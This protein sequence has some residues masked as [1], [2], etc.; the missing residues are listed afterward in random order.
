MGNSTVDA[1]A[2]LSAAIDAL[3]ALDLTDLPAEHAGEFAA[4]LVVQEQRVAATRARALAVFDGSGAAR[5]A[6]ATSTA[7]WLRGTANLSPGDAAAAV[8]AARTVRDLPQ[9]AE[10]FAAGEISWRHVDLLGKALRKHGVEHLR[11]AEPTLL[12]LAKAAPPAELA[13]ALRRLDEALDPDG[14]ARREVERWSKRRLSLVTGMDGL[15]FLDAVMADEDAELVRSVLLPL[16]KPTHLPDGTPDDRTGGQRMMDALLDA[17]KRVADSGTLPE[18][19]GQKPHVTLVVPLDTL[20]A[21]TRTQAGSALTALWGASFGSEELRQVCCDAAV[22]PVVVGPAMSAPVAGGDGAALDVA[23]LDSAALDPQE[24]RAHL[25]AQGRF[26]GLGQP[27]ALGESART[28]S[29]AQRRA[30]TVRDG[31]C[32]FPGCDRPP[33]FT[34][35]HHVVFWSH[36]GPTDLDNLILLC[37]RH[38]RIVHHDHWR[39]EHDPHRPGLF[40]FRHPTADQW[41]RGQH[42]VD[43]NPGSRLPLSWLDQGQ[44]HDEKPDS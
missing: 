43:R 41:L 31:G 29:V 5:A 1:L 34:D 35:A 9:T 24:L 6:G 14:A 20:R 27:L 4:A 39:V 21:E 40:R 37:R 8:R 28:V 3:S 25:D 44:A 13:V 22:T 23:A 15:T 19:G 12:P 17:L 32:I 16:A 11:A 18:S 38:H 2:A 10:A 33:S 42:S 36:S 30:L 26:L 7:A